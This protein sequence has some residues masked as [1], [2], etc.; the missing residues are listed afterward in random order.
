[1]GAIVLFYIIISFPTIFI[2][3]FVI[4]AAID[5]SATAMIFKEIRDMLKSQ[6]GIEASSEDINEDTSHGNE[7]VFGD[8]DICPACKEK[9]KETDKICPSCGLTII[10]ENK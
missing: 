9:I 8:Y 1:M 6:Y 3:Y 7:L 4:Q 2:L 10:D 5:N